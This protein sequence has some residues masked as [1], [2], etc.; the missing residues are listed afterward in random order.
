M[1]KKTTAGG[2]WDDPEMMPP[3]LKEKSST[4]M[5]ENAQEPDINPYANFNFDKEAKKINK[6]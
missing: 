4:K 3:P 6:R 1:R 5:S 2:Y